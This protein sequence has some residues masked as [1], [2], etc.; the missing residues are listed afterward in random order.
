M[1]SRP[2]MPC[3]WAKR[4]VKLLRRLPCG[5][6]HVAI[7]ALLHSKAGF[8]EIIPPFEECLRLPAL[9]PLADRVA[10]GA[11]R[12]A[13][14]RR[15][16]HRLMRRIYLV[17]SPD[18]AVRREMATGTG[19]ASALLLFGPAYRLGDLRSIE[20]RNGKRLREVAHVTGTAFLFD[21]A[22]VDRIRIESRGGMG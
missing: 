16:E 18:L 22:R 12:R 7:L 17:P 8:I 5:A 10:V 19:Q 13:L 3:N 14:N 6:R 11:H 1:S 15:F 21:I 9:N 4:H 2:Q 20:G